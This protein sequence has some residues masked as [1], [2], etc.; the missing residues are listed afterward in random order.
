MSLWDRKVV[1]RMLP[2]LDSESIRLFQFLCYSIKVMCNMK[3][4][5]IAVV[6]IVLGVGRIII[7][8]R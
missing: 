6:N 7:L 4:M 5:T 3:S 2:A 8:T 1:S